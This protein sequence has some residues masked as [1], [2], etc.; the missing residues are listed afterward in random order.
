MI[1]KDYIKI[2]PSYII[3]QKT[4]TCIDCKKR[5]SIFLYDYRYDTKKIKN[6]C[7]SCVIIKKI[8][9]KKN[10]RDKVIAGSRA[11]YKKFK[12]EICYRMST[13][14]YIKH[15]KF[16]VL[17][18]KIQRGKDHYQNNKTYYSV[19]SAKQR[20]KKKLRVFPKGVECKKVMAIYKKRDQLNKKYGAKQYAVD[21]IIPLQHEFVCGLH[22]ANNLQI[23]TT[24]ENAQKHN[25]FIP[26]HNE[27]FYNTKYWKNMPT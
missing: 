26:G 20:A 19:K 8:Q 27:A 22:V 15:K 6:Q 25:K 21:H 2:N 12:K 10:N 9:W 18:R 5:K 14:Y 3:N 11:R 1:L 7:H 17:K 23:L 4:K 16:D 24:L 13:E